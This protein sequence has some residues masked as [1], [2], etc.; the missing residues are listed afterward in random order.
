M[1]CALFYLAAH[2]F[3]LLEAG[4]SLGIRLL[5]L[6]FCPLLFAELA[7]TQEPE[8]TRLPSSKTILGPSPGAPQRTN[9][10]PETIALSPDGRYAALLNNGYGTVESGI[11]QSIA[12]VDL[13]TNQVVDFPDDR[14]AENAHQSYFVGLAFNSD[15]TRLYASMGS[16]TD[17]VG[18]HPG[19]TG[20]GIAVYRFEQR[21]TYSRPLSQDCVAVRAAGN[22]CWRGLGTLPPVTPQHGPDETRTATQFGG[23]IRSKLS[24]LETGDFSRKK[25][26]YSGMLADGIS[27]LKP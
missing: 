21:Q 20:N 8:R 22:S 12:I 4:L 6:L 16:L 1:A 27:E 25:S 18:E 11:K 23:A 2:T 13:Q 5:A 19:N 10:F 9:G 26:S 7:A 3:G 24:L 14:L 15:G 17:P